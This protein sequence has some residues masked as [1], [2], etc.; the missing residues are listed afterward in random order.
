ME[1]SAKDKKLLVYL[2]ALGLIA[3][4]Y[5]FGA[6]IF[7]EKQT[8]L[9][10]EVMELQQKVN[11]CNEIYANREDIEKKIADANVK[12]AE[13]SNKFYG[14]LDQ[15]NTLMMLRSIENATNVWVRRV[16]F[17][18]EEAM[19]GATPEGTE[20]TEAGTEAAEGTEA[21]PEGALPAATLTGFKQNLNIDYN[22]NYGN[23]KQFVNYVTNSDK[24]LYISSLSASYS[25]DGGEISG[26]M[27]LSQYALTGADIE[28]EAPNLNNITVGVGNIFTTLEG[29]TSV[30][31]VEVQTL[32]EETAESDEPEETQSDETEEKPENSGNAQ[33]Q[34]EE[35]TPV[36]MGE[37][38]I[39][40]DGAGARRPRQ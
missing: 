8:A 37:A 17:Q 4:A 39:A 16:A 3:A 9:N 23:F 1:L 7:L 24:R 18:V 22:A 33:E 34:P 20:G 5:F 32:T 25:V 6:R 21:T 29:G 35:S 11:H 19:I 15:E 2:L 12:Y 40:D 10:S 31:S 36:Q 38:P 14:G 28:Y 13:T 26:A 30:P 27:V